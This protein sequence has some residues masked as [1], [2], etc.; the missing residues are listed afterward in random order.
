LAGCPDLA[1]IS[2]RKAIFVHGCFWHRHPGCPGACIPKSNAEYWLPKLAKNVER[3]KMATHNLTLSG[4]KI[5]VVWECQTRRIES[6]QPR[7]VRFL[8]A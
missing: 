6:L 7:V 3:D 4:W 2:Q 5:L 8:A 1:F